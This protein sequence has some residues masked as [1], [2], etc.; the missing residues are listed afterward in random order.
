MWVLDR[1]SEQGAEGNVDGRY[2][3]EGNVLE[4][5]GWDEWWLATTGNVGSGVVMVWKGGKS[6]NG[7]EGG[8]YVRGSEAR[9]NSR[10]RWQ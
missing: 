3:G 9:G 10:W 4:M 5:V 7:G 1:A 2:C 8:T 6:V